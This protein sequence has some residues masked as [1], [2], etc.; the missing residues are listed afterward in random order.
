M[1]QKYWI[2][3]ML[4]MIISRLCSGNTEYNKGTLLMQEY[5]RGAVEDVPTTVSRED[6]LESLSSD[7]IISLVSEYKNHPV[8]LV[9]SRV[10]GLAAQVAFKDSS[11]EIQKRAIKMFVENVIND[12]YHNSK[13]SIKYLINLSRLEYYDESMKE[14]I[15]RGFREHEKTRERILLIGIAGLRDLIPDLQKI[16]DE[17]PDYTK[18]HDRWVSPQWYAHCALARLGVEA[19]IQHCI[20]MVESVESVDKRLMFRMKYIAYMRQPA[21]MRVLKKYLDSDGMDSSG[22]FRLSH[23]QRV[24]DLLERTMD[25][26]PVMEKIPKGSIHKTRKEIRDDTINEARAYMADEAN[27]KIIR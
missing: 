14:M 3:I 15:R 11:E 23:A 2:F 16:V 24:Y 19:S 8:E 18:K 25:D 17:D 12:I 7:T 21:G 4:L 13:F 9:R 26:F 5:V 22:D 1:K 27:W 6:M 10:I 20:D